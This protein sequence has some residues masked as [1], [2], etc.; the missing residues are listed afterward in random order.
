MIDVQHLDSSDRMIVLA[1]RARRAPEEAA[2]LGRILDAEGFEHAWGAARDSHVEALVGTTLAGEL[3]PGALPSAW[4]TFLEENDVRVRALVDL[5]GRVS[6][7]LAARGC[8]CVAVEAGGVMLSSDL[9]FRAYGSSDVDLLVP[10]G[11]L[12]DLAAV[13]REL[14]GTAGE[15]GPRT[16]RIK[17]RWDRGSLSP[18]WIEGCDQP[19]DRNWVALPYR[20]RSAVWLERRRR[21]RRAGDIWVLD[22]SD[23][24]VFVGMH[25]SLHAYVLPPGLRLHVDVDR[26]VSDNLVNWDRVVN[27]ARAIGAPTRVFVSLALATAVMGTAIPDHVLRALAPE[28]WRVGALAALL[29][30]EGIVG[31]EPR[32]RGSRRAL[33]DAL[34]DDRGM[35]R[36]LGALA[37]PPPNWTRTHF[38]MAT[39]P[40]W[41]AYLRRFRA[42]ARRGYEPARAALE[43]PDTLA[44]EN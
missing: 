37:F 44:P 3:G 26:L 5:V 39:D 42:L 32:L 16:R 9:P 30:G 28:G 17:Y 22:H 29:N 34:I 7:A 40:A 14:G 13:C 4:W 19:F 23:A 10:T 27:E 12:R 36:W 41:L 25:T 2:E 35:L 21:S 33:L 38:G 24:V 11:R 8:P 31:N 1:A 6:E 18:L 15:R 43:S 20:D